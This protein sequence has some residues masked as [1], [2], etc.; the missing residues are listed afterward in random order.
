MRP[1]LTHPACSP[2]LWVRL[3]LQVRLGSTQHLR[4]TLRDTDARQGREQPRP[5]PARIVPV[6]RITVNRTAGS[7]AGFRELYRSRFATATSDDGPCV[8]LSALSRCS[9]V[10][11][12]GVVERR[13]VLRRPTLRA[14]SGGVRHRW[15][16]PSKLGR[17]R[18]VA[19]LA[20]GDLGKPTKGR[21]R[22]P[23]SDVHPSWHRTSV[24]CASSLLYV[25]REWG[26]LKGWSSGVACVGPA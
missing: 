5:S 6:S 8:G 7:L 16:R 14:G 3:A 22:P 24:R 15:R 10:V 20:V 18:V 25:H 1:A 12:H 19:D 4:G 2:Q 23:S 26:R 11:R 13:A 17:V 9:P 21:S